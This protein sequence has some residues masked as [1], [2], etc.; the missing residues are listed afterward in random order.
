[1]PGDYIA[2]VLK[3]DEQQLVSLC[4]KYGIVSYIFMKKTT[5]TWRQTYTIY[6]IKMA[7]GSRDV[8]IST[9]FKEPHF[10]MAFTMAAKTPAP[11]TVPE[12]HKKTKSDLHPLCHGQGLDVRQE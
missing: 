9:G 2:R 3:H 11:R 5:Q 6:T 4:T 10:I 7:K 1:M 8:S 12:N